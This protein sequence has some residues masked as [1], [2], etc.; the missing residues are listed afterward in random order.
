MKSFILILL[1]SFLSAMTNSQFYDESWAVIIGINN[2]H[3]INRLNYAVDDAQDIHD[4]LVAKFNFPVDN[5]AL[6]LNDEATYNN[7]KTSLYEM[8]E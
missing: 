3:N 1:L 2:Y 4:M 6:L 7:I 5:I 8:A